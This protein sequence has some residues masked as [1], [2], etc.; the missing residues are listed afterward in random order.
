MV[1]KGGYYISL[2]KSIYKVQ[3]FDITIATKGANMMVTIIKSVVNYGQPQPSFR[4]RDFLRVYVTRHDI[5]CQNA[6]KRDV[7][8]TRC[9]SDV[10]YATAL[11]CA[12]CTSLS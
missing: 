3:R 2:V 9:K 12:I 8:K 10:I 5:L 1:A 11:C 7:G 4:K 6:V